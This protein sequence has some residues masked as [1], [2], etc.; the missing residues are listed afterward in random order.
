MNNMGKKLILLS[1]KNDELPILSEKKAQAERDYKIEVRKQI[2]FHK[3][4]GHP[5]TIITKLVEGHKLVAELKF[6]YDVATEI[7]K[8]CLESMKDIRLQVESYRSLLT[9]FRYA[10]KEG[11]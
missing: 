5:V 9:W 11:A 7:Y 8:A 1:Q 10:E 2:L 4:E 3:S 6:K